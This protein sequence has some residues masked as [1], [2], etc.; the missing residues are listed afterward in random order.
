[1][2]RFTEIFKM[3]FISI[4]IVFYTNIIAFGQEEDFDELTWRDKVFFGFNMGWASNTE[5]VFEFI[6]VTGY[7]ITPRWLGGIGMKYE[8]YKSTGALFD[9]TYYSYSTSIYG[10]TL[11]TNYEFLKD[12]PS[13]GLSFFVHTEL[14]S[15][16]LSKKYFK[17]SVSSGRFFHTSLLI[18]GGIR[19]RL[20]RRASFNLMILFASH[21]THPSPYPDNPFLRFALLF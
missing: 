1:M 15:L 2:I 10:G 7:R 12:I 4:L 19:Q 20:G 14:E 6:P 11:F 13:K 3:L 18:G 8:Y 21:T 17:D 16:N 9:D 5:S